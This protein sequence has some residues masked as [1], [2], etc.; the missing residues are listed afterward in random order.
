MSFL[1]SYADLLLNYSL[2]LKAGER[3]YIETT[4]LAEPLVKLLYQKALDLGALPY[5]QLSFCDQERILLEH[6]QNAEQWGLLP[7]FYGEAMTHFEAYLNIRAPFWSR[8]LRPSPKSQALKAR[9]AAKAPAQQAYQLRTANLSLRRC[10]CEYPTMAG[11]ENAGMSLEEY[12]DFIWRACYLDRPNPQAAWEALSRR[13]AKIIEVLS[14]YSHF[15]YLG[16]ETDLHFSTQG[17]TWINS[18][19]HTNMPSGEVFTA[20]VEDSVEG[21]VYF[22]YPS[23]YTGKE[24]SGI[25]LWLR[26]GEVY[27]AEAE[28]GQDVLDRILAQEGARRFGEAAIGCNPNIQQMVRNI[29]FDEKIGGTIHL[30]LGQSYAQCGGKNDSPVHWDMIT[31][32]RQGAI[33]GDGVC[34]YRNGNFLFDLPELLD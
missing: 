26:A 9:R 17:R 5:V 20:P 2:S 3:V 10:L 8:D 21:Q 22:S 15:R 6:G 33:Y 28:Q 18:D 19:G 27:R 14:Q 30:A 31:D 29:L 13:Q 32:M 23:I 11:A 25:R 4:T 34:L 24:V 16:P 12:Q 7:Q 1:A